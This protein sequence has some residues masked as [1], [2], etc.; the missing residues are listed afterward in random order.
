M[1]QTGVKSNKEKRFK[2][3][4]LY[5]ILLAFFFFISVHLLVN[6]L[7]KFWLSSMFWSFCA[8]C[9]NPNISRINWQQWNY[10]NFLLFHV[11]KLVTNI[12]DEDYIFILFIDA[13]WTEKTGW[14]VQT[15]NHFLLTMSK[16]INRKFYG[17]KNYKQ[18]S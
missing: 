5:I 1:T 15:W 4:L 17:R 18:F 3:M 11:V 8:F 6:R 2:K 13:V 12:H 9:V 7:R 16:W 10:Y 14:I